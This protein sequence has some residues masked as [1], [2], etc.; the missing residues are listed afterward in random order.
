MCGSV[1]V[2]TSLNAFTCPLV[3]SASGG[4][5]WRLNDIDLSPDLSGI[6]NLDDDPAAGATGERRFTL[7]GSERTAQAVVHT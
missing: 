4:S 2:W 6:L 1:H 3:S 7:G 5:S